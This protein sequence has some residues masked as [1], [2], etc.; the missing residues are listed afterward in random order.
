[1][2]QMSR[3]KTTKRT[4]KY[5]ADNLYRHFIDVERHAKKEIRRNNA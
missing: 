5:S 2:A 3:A 1:M 4:K